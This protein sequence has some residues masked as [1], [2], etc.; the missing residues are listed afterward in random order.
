MYIKLKNGL[1]VEALYWPDKFRARSHRLLKRII[2]TQYTVDLI[3][4]PQIPNLYTNLL[5]FIVPISCYL[6]YVVSTNRI[7]IKRSHLLL[8][9]V[10]LIP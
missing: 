8:L 6:V 9:F 5:L 7:H 4:I 3:T 1:V 10:P 2:T